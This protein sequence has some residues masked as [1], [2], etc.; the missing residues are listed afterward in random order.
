MT[1]K[2]TIICLIVL[3]VVGSFVNFYCTNLLMEDI[4]NVFGGFSNADF[5]STFPALM[6]AIDFVLATIFVIRFYKYPEYKK[7]IV[8]LYLLLL[9]IFSVTGFIFA[10]LTGLVSYKSFVAPYPFTGYTIISM[11]VH[12]MLAICSMVLRIK[13]SKKLEDDKDKKK[14]TFKYVLYNILLSLL[15]YLVFDKFGAL[16]WSPTYIFFRTF[17]MTFIF[18]FSLILPML[19]LVQCACYNLG[20]YENKAKFGLIISSCLLCL[21]LISHVLIIVIG[22]KNTDMISSIS[23]SLPLERLA[24]KPIDTIFRTIYC[25]ALGIYLVIISFKKFKTNK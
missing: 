23:M 9:F 22:A 21:V 18:Y 24:T 5:I 2:N 10:I 13:L 15:I 3:S 1:R 6:F 16:L 17:D 11:I 19:L 12:L 20:L 7:S 14:M 25:L 8:R 4:L